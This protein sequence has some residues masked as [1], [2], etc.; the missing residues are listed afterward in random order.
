MH[1]VKS[2]LVAFLIAA[3]PGASHAAV[4]ISD[5]GGGRIGTYLDRY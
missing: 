5:D 1:F 2:L 3:G 4:R